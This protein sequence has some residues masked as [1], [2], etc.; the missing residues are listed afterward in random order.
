[1]AGENVGL[2]LVVPA[3]DGRGLREGMGVERYRG[4]GEGGG[5]G[6]DASC[7]VGILGDIGG[8]EETLGESRRDSVGDSRRTGLGD[9]ATEYGT[10]AIFSSNEY[11]P[12]LL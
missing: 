2:V 6:D 3:D 4:S 8:G 12:I 7:R 10:T 11:R 1:M 9:S 5:S